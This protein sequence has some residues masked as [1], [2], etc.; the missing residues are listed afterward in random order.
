M[1]LLWK[2]LYAP[3]YLNI[4]YRARVICALAFWINTICILSPYIR[5][6]SAQDTGVL[7][8]RTTKTH[9]HV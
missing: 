9:L 3:L 6:G 1:L 2:Q 7:V 4:M 5:T 8:T